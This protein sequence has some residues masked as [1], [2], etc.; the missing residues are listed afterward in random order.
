MKRG[1]LV[2]ALL[3][4]AGCNVD[5][6][7]V[8]AAQAA[9]GWRS[10]ATEDDR[11][12]LRGWRSAWTEALRKAGA[13]GHGEAI[14]REGALLDPDSALDGS[15]AP[16]GDYRCRTIKVGSRSEGGLD[17]VAYQPFLC[18]IVEDQGVVTFTKLS[19]SQRPVGVLLPDGDR[20]HIFLG[21][22]VLGDES[23]A[24]QYGRDR[25]R[26]MIALLERIG[27]RRW[28]LVFPSPHFESRLDVME[29]VPA[30]S[31][32]EGW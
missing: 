12:R 7:P 18:R 6:E 24:I 25:E 3:A 5:R 14:A 4:S 15:I 9:A 29:L 1:L 20:R 31:P 16:P 26:D 13:G 2:G 23:R 27:D 8:P 21:T 19:G 17:F 30:H 11:A 10:I 28:R 22:L 32:Q